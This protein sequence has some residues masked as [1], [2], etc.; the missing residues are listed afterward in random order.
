MLQVC[1]KIELQRIGIDESTVSK[2]SSN[3]EIMKSEQTIC[4]EIR[5]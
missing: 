5:K 4:L 3:S 2:T 1:E